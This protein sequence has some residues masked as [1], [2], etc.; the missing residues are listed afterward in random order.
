MGPRRRSQR[1]VQIARDADLPRPGATARRRT[2][3]ARIGFA[4]GSRSESLRY[5]SRVLAKREHITLSIGP[6]G[7]E[8]EPVED[9]LHRRRD[10]EAR[11]VPAEALARLCARADAEGV[12]CYLETDKQ[13]NV[14]LYESAGYRVITDETVPTK[15]GF[16]MWTMQRSART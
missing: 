4:T 6:R 2:P 1:G 13:R 12:P 10:H 3:V 15:P 14:R 5:D 16:R 7:R 11:A 8:L 9:P